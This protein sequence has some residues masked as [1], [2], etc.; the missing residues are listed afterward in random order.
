MPDFIK[1]KSD[2]GN[3]KA[4][5]QWQ[6]FATE[7]P[8]FFLD[9]SEDTAQFLLLALRDAVATASP[10][11]QRAMAEAHV[12]VG[13]HGV[14]IAFPGEAHDL[15]FGNPEER[16]SPHPIIRRTINHEQRK[17]A[18]RFNNLLHERLGI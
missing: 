14:G 12:V 4:A 9:A 1:L 15:E 17:V 5:K 8:G 18:G 10:A 13:D 16:R 6:S 3:A 7:A 2:G 11:W